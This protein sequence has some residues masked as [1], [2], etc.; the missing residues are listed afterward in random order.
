MV[1]PIPVYIDIGNL[2]LFALML[3]EREFMAGPGTSLFQTV[4][5]RLKMVM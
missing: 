5:D 1:V 4:V 3:K 2:I